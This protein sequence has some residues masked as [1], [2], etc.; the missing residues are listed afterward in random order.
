MT[1]KDR[2]AFLE[3]SAATHEAL[4]GQYLGQITKD[5]KNQ[6]ARLQ[7][8][9]NDA[10]LALAAVRHEIADLKDSLKSGS[11]SGH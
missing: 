8:A 6:H 7:G 2:I 11:P 1:L 10:K 9:V 3:A 5:N 4:I